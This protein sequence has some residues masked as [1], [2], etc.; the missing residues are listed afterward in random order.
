[1][2]SMSNYLVTGVTERQDAFGLELSYEY[3]SAKNVDNKSG[4]IMFLT[5]SRKKW[6]SR[7]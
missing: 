3:E 5:L 1:M 4:G 6:I 2:R 7:C